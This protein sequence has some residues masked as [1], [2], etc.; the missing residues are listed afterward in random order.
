MLR[1]IH[2]ILLLFALLIGGAGM[3]YVQAAT[4]SGSCGTNAT[5]SL[6][7]ET[8]I[9]VI[10][11]TGAIDDYT[12]TNQIPWY[13]FRS[14]IIGVSI[15]NGITRIGQATC[16]NCFN[17]TSVSMGTGVTSIGTSA[18]YGCSKLPSITIGNHVTTIEQSAFYNCSALKSIT[19]P[20]SVTSIGTSAFVGCWAMESVYITDLAAWCHINFSSYTSSPF[21][22]NARSDV[23]HGGGNLYVNGTK[24]TTLRIPDGIT[25]IPHRAFFG[26]MGITSIQF[27][28]V[29]TIGNHAFAA[30][31]GLTS[32]TFPEGVTAINYNT[33]GNC[34]QLQTIYL[35]ASLTTFGDYV[36]WNCDALTDIY[37]SWTENIPSLSTSITDK[38]PQSD[39][40]LHVPCGT[41]PLYKEAMRWWSYTIV[42]ETVASGTCGADGDNL[43]WNLCDG[44]LTI[45]GTGAMVHYWAYEDIPWWNYRGSIQRI[46]IEEGVTS[47]GNHAFVQCSNLTSVSLPNTLT[48]ISF[49]AFGHCT[50]LPSLTI[51]SSVTS[52]AGMF[53]HNTPSLTDVYVSWTD[54]DVP[55]MPADLHPYDASQKRLHIPC[56]QEAAYTAKGWNNKFVFEQ[57]NTHYTITV[58]SDDPT[59]GTVDARKIEE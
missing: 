40:T 59:M 22:R 4:Y 52:M 1:R 53:I 46:V 35:P 19:I 6:N 49:L 48:A 50:S 18:F 25:E 26:F 10:S 44:T 31:H 54:D 27:N 28:Q 33:F 39:I 56:G 14:S 58:E 51:P 11:G 15:S 21:Y 17:L 57:E 47:I 7:T 37:V 24:V 13:S 30:C 12:N 45:S 5:W 23:A 29:T 43:T 38:Y 8:A 16:Y 36:W 42:D 3:N 34:S 55:T 20:P 2:S 41:I 9:L 32:L